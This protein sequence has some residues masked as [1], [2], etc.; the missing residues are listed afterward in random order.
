[1]R[2]IKRPIRKEDVPML[3]MLHAPVIAICEA[4]N[5]I[6]ANHLGVPYGKKGK[7]KK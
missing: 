1:M 7:P 6:I 2:Y 4:A 3:E 5:S